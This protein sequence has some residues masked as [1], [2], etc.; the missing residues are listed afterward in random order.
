MKVLASRDPS[1]DSGWVSPCLA[2]E[3]ASQC[4]AAPLPWFRGCQ[5]HGA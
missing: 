5:V 4:L 3:D 1:A 2:A